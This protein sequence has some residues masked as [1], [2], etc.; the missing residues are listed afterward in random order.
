MKSEYVNLISSIILSGAILRLSGA[1]SSLGG[2]VS[3]LVDTVASWIQSRHNP[4]NVDDS[5]PQPSVSEP[6][7]TGIQ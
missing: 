3:R 5:G 7:E 2:S 6:P 1:V 4:Y